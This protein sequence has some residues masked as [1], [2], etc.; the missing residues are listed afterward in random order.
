MSS[1][2]SRIQ[3]TRD[4]PYL[5]SAGVR[6]LKATI[7]VDENGVADA[8]EETEKTKTPEDCALCRCGASG[9]KPFCDGTHTRIR[10]DGTETAGNVPYERSSQAIR[11]PTLVLRDKTE[12]CIGA[13]F[14]DKGLGTWES[15]KRSG[16][17]AA[18]ELAIRTSGNCPSGR[19]VCYE[20]ETGKPIEPAYE[21]S[22]AL[23]EDPREGLSGPIWVR[24]KIPV[25]SSEGKE[26]EPRNRVTLCRCGASGN[27]P[28]CD[29]THID[30][31]F[32]D[33]K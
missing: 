13:G 20:K 24:G 29:G 33:G 28:F 7:V 30:V 11:G 26:Y 18:R 19:L 14:C 8:W 12:L 2:K 21:Q 10:F 15:T 23:V 9:N 3:V 5:V 27:K 16:T 6:L 32:S 22:V 1:S 25:Q 4:G 31:K 17:A